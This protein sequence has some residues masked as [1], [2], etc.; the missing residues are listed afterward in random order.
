MYS[1]G[2]EEF[3]EGNGFRQMT[4]GQKVDTQHSFFMLLDPKEVTGVCQPP[5]HPTS[6]FL[7]LNN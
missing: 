2:R 3:G 4:G 5:F 6:V 7:L 1:F